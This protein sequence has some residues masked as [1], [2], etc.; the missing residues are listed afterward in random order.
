MTALTTSPCAASAQAASSD[1]GAVLAQ[2]VTGHKGR[3]RAA[4]RQP[5]TPQGDGG[6]E[7]GRLG[8]VGLIEQLFRTL[9]G[10]YPEVIAQSIGGFFEGVEDQRVLRAQLGQHAEGLR[11]LSWKDE[12][13]GCRHVTSP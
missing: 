3:T 5:Q 10:Q 13:E 12:C 2:A 7:D 8:L 9:L 6:G 1:Q 4:F 11:A